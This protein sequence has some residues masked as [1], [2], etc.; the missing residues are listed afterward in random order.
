[1]EIL[2]NAY[3][4]TK[5]PKVRFFDTFGCAIW[6]F[7]YV[8]VAERTGFAVQYLFFGFVVWIILV[9]N[10]FYS[11]QFLL[12]EMQKA[13]KEDSTV[14]FENTIQR[15][16]TAG[17]VVQYTNSNL[18]LW[19]THTWFIFLSNHGSIILKKARIKAM[20]SKLTTNA[21]YSLVIEYDTN[22]IFAA[23]CGTDSDKVVQLV[24]FRKKDGEC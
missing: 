20:Y 23:A 19:V 8:A 3:R 22:S 24:G 6:F 7:V 17:N 15:E 9:H 14:E 21:R 10:V 4:D 18:Y 16:I 2:L 12:R 1:M 5:K 11:P 13:I